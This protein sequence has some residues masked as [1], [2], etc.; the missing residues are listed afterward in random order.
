M[1]DKAYKEASDWVARLHADDRG[2]EDEQAFRQWLYASPENSAQFERVSAIW[3]DVGGLEGHIVREDVR[4][5]MVNRRAVLAGTVATVFAG[6]GLFAWS[7]ARAGLYETDVGEQKRITLSDGTQLFLDT[8]TR[9]KVHMGSTRRLSLHRGRVHSTIA[10]SDAPFIMEAGGYQ[11][12]AMRGKF[13]VQYEGEQISFLAVEGAA[14][15]TNDT[16][17]SKQPMM[18]RAG[19]RFLRDKGRE[20]MERPDIQDVMAWQSG[21][22]AFRSETLNEA[23]AEMNRYSNQ[24]IILADPAIASLRISGVFSVGDNARFART[25][26][27]LLPVKAHVGASQIMISAP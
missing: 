23:V 2:P 24:P 25:L 13:G 14:R 21:R 20:Q 15:I 6:G 7:D 4:P 27:N 10:R 19:D 26:Q 17:T 16:M 12:M 11:L 8:N 1:N 3:H 9:L 18:I 5:V 22:A